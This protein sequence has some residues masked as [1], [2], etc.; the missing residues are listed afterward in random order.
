MAFGALHRPTIHADRQLSLLTR[1]VEDANA[2]LIHSFLSRAGGASK[3]VLTNA[4]SENIAVYQHGRSCTRVGTSRQDN[5]TNACLG[6]G[7][8]V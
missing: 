3:F 2:A 5:A 4:V 7:L 1:S 8:G 6:F